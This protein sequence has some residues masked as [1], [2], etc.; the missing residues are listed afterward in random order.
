MSES[1]RLRPVSALKLRQHVNLYTDR[2]APRSVPFSARFI[3]LY[4]LMLVLAIAAFATLLKRNE[5]NAQVALTRA[6]NE[7]ALEQSNL[8]AVRSRMGLDHQLSLEK[9]ITQTENE[10]QK[11]RAILDLLKTPLLE[12][13]ISPAQTLAALAGAHQAGVW[14]TRIRTNGNDRRI[15]LEGGTL[16]AQSLPGYIQALNAQG[17]FRQARFRMFSAQESAADPMAGGPG[18]RYLQFRLGSG[19]NPAPTPEKVTL[20]TPAGHRPS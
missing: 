11:R 16:T 9:Q 17:P 4:T 1:V 14:L 13:Q 15:L 3:L 6:Q 19:V 10:A 2:F 12:S 18:M 8:E 7:L 5:N 20:D